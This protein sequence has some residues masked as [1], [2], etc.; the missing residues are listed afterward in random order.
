VSTRTLLA[1]NPNALPSTFAAGVDGR[2]VLFSAALSIVTGVLFGLAP[3]LDAARANLHDS[4]KGG[5]RGASGGRGGDRARRG[6]V[7]AQVGLAVMLL[8]AAGLLVRS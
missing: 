1:L 5:G 3:A 6:L 4:L 7:I 2:V 8:V